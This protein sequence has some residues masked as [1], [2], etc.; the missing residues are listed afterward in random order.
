MEYNRY[1]WKSSCLDNIGPMDLHFSMFSGLF[2][3]DIRLQILSA[4]LLYIP[5]IVVPKHSYTVIWIDRN[6]SV[7]IM[8]VGWNDE[9]VDAEMEGGPKPLREGLSQTCRISTK[10]MVSEDSM[11]G[12]VAVASGRQSPLRTKLNTMFQILLTSGRTDTLICLRWSD[13]DPGCNTNEVWKFNNFPYKGIFLR[14]RC[15]EKKALHM[16]HGAAKTSAREYFTSVSLSCNTVVQLPAVQSPPGSTSG[17]NLLTTQ[18]VCPLTV[19]LEY[20]PV[21]DREAGNM[22][23]PDFALMSVLL[24]SVFWTNCA[25][26]HAV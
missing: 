15:G 18:T 4:G 14:E 11:T 25:L 10:K 13:F 8:T 22:E 21:Y 17:T 5:D 1:Y 16:S 7:T 20:P 26:P 12:Y 24:S 23:A 3:E 6:S 19:L 9:F 2:R